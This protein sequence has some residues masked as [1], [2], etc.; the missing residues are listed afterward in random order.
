MKKL[1]G[2][3]STRVIQAAIAKSHDI[4]T[5]HDEHQ[6]IKTK[7]D[8]TEIINQAKGILMRQRNLDE[9]Q[10]LEMLSTMAKK[11]KIKLVDLS[12]QLIDTAKLLI[13]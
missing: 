10:A 7:F 8:E 4:T 3:R 1:I 2:E 9:Y 11:R 13:I 6:K 5:L 12:I